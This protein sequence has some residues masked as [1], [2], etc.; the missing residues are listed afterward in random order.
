MGMTTSD[1]DKK[2]YSTADTAFISQNVYLYSASEGL[3]TVVR[4]MTD[5]DDLSKS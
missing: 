5:R 1:E 2:M 3:A 4:G